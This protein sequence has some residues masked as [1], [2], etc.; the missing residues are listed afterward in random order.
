MNF[1]SLQLTSVFT[2]ALALTAC[3][4]S[5]S[6]SSS[7]Q[8][9]PGDSTNQISDD[10]VGSG[11]NGNDTSDDIAQD[12]DSS[13]D[14]QQDNEQPQPTLS[15]TSQPV[16]GTM[17][18]GGDYTLSLNVDSSDTYTVTWLKDGVSIGQANSLLLNNLTVNDTGSY[19]CQVVSGDLNESCT[20]FSLTVMDA[21]SI[22]QSPS[23]SIVTEGDSASLSIVAEGSDL[24]Y[25]W[26]RDGVAVSGANDSSLSLNNVALA[27]AGSYTCVVSNAVG[28][29][30]SAGANLAVL[31]AVTSANVAISWVSPNQRQ[32]G[33]ALNPADISTYRV[34]YGPAASAGYDQS[35]DVNSADTSIV[36][37]GLNE[38][39]YKFAVSAVDA[40][41]VESILS[42]DFL[43]AVQ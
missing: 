18:S 10:S 26:Y 23:N 1:K 13:Q 39:D 15:I 33:S 36:I 17:A 9:Q 37:E 32:D 38:G 43:L 2:L 4:G 25:Q 19:S 40:E 6:G 29:D 28:S 42:D 3:G 5:G 16:S 35:L 27:D 30:S 24:S 34:Y 8:S 41:G 31:E 12:D 7:T 21:P 11:D 22:V 20:A 14:D